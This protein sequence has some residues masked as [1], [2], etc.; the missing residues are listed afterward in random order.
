GLERGI[1]VA[2]ARERPEA[3][4]A[5]AHVLTLVLAQHARQQE[6]LQRFLEADRIDALARAQRGEAR[7]L[8]VLDRADLHQRPELADPRADLAAALRIL[9]Q[10]PDAARIGL[11]QGGLLV[12]HLLLERAP[13]LLHQ[14]HPRL[15]A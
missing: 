15:L 13:E 11:V 14:R 7:L 5:H 6:Q 1:G 8:L 2:A 10:H 4:D 3:A 12:V 9:A